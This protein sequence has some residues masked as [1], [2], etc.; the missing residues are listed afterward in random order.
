MVYVGALVYLLDIEMAEIEAALE[1]NFGGKR[2]PIELNMDMVR[3][4]IPGR[5]RTSK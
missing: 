4:P 2:K 3:A 1:W 5:R